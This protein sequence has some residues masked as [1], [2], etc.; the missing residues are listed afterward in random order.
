MRSIVPMHG[1]V[2][3]PNCKGLIGSYSPV[4]SDCGLHL[5]ELGVVELAEIDEHNRLALSAAN[6]L[7][8]YAAIS[9]VFVFLA[10]II[11]AIIAPGIAF[12]EIF[13]SIVA[14]GLFWWRY[15]LWYQRYGQNRFSDE[16]FEE[17]VETRRRTLMIGFALTGVVLGSIYWTTT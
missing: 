5:T 16:I 4:C 7:F 1:V 9:N 17:A 14:L 2:K 8:S 6:D 10:F 11:G 12:G 15:L 3:C 13:V